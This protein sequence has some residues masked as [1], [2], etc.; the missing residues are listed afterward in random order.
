MIFGCSCNSRDW[1]MEDLESQSLD[2]EDEGFSCI[3]LVLVI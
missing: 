2:F 1:V 3:A